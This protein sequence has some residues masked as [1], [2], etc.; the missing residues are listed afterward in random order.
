MR[1]ERLKKQ[2]QNSKH[3]EKVVFWFVRHS[4]SEGNTLGDDTPV[5]HDTSI[6]LKGKDEA[7]SIA[8]Y[9]ADNNINVTH[10]YSAPSNRS[11][12]TAEIIGNK[13]NIPVVTM[14]D[15]NERNWG[16]L[17]DHT[18][19]EVA[20]KLEK[21]DLD[22]R[23]LFMPDGGE[24]WEQM[25]ERLFNTFEQIAKESHSGENILIVTH[26]G[27]LRA[28]LPLLAKAGREKHEDYSMPLG[29]LSKFSFEKDKFD[30]VGLVP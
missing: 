12:Q 8:K 4:E 27:C 21:M 17:G 3:P 6:T 29:S 1:V 11:K 28:V 5:M 16:D 20:Q 26:R 30:F 23:Y 22:Q 9:F 10:I 15:L 13:L 25:E 18:W 14:G 7:Q 24:T 19:K 2:V